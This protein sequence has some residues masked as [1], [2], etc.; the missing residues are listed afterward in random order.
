MILENV[1]VIDHIKDK[2]I[3]HIRLELIHEKL[4]A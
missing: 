1:I 2:V 3:D 4:K